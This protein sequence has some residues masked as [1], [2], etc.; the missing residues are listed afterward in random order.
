MLARRQV[1]VGDH[2]VG[3][4]VGY[5]YGHRA[6]AHRLAVHEHAHEVAGG[7]R[8]DLQADPVPPG[9]WHQGHKAER[10]VVRQAGVVDVVGK[11]LAAVS[12]CGRC[13][14]LCL[15]EGSGSW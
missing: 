12:D 3:R 6:A 10:A 8:V 1:H 5:G 14:R 15:T 9:C 7:V 4:R 11:K 2:D 13:A